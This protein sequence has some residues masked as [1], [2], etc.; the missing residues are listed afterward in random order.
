[1]K[2]IIPI[3]LMLYCSIQLSQDSKPEIDMNISISDLHPNQT[4][5]INIISPDNQKVWEYYSTGDSSFLDLK[6]NNWFTKEGRYKFIVHVEYKDTVRTAEEGCDFIM[7]GKEY[8]V[9]AEID[10]T[11]SDFTKLEGKKTYY[12]SDIYIRKYYLSSDSV[13]I[14]EK[15]IPK[16]DGMPEYILQNNTQ[17]I[18]YG[19]EFGG[20]FFGWIEKLDSGKWKF[21][22]RGGFCGTVGRA[23]PI[24]PDGSDTTFEGFFIGDVKHFEKGKYK[25][26]FFYTSKEVEWGHLIFPNEVVDKKVW[27]FYLLEK[28]FEIKDY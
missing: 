4:L 10:F 24:Y 18:I 13:T 2:K 3:L 5:E 22:H 19:T 9:D 23:D 28:E 14:K 25:Y 15:W 7:V 20:H 11:N 16:P 27:D 8:K 1:M 12:L 26:C 21:Y 17:R 6:A